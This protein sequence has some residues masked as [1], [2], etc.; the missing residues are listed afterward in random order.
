MGNLWRDVRYGLRKLANNKGFAAVA[1]LALALGIGPNVAIFSIIWATF[2]A[3]LPYPDADQLVVVWTKVRGERS[4]SRTDD[5]LQY[6]AQSRSFQNLD[7]GAWKVLH[8]TNPDHS[9]DETTGL[10]A[11]PGYFT[12]NQGV[13]IALGRDFLPEEGVPGKDHEVILTHRVW[14]ERFHGDPAI[15]G[16]PILID[17]QPY[18]VVG[19][20]EAGVRDRVDGVQFGVPLALTPGMH[21]PEWGN[22][23]GR[24]KRG[25]TIA[26]A[27]AEL[28]VIDRQLAATRSGD[29]PKNAWTISVEPLKNDWMDKKLARNLWLLLAA[30]GFVLLIACANLA[31]LLLAK[32]SSRQ[33][34]LAVRAAMGATRRQVFGQ[35]ITE[36]LTLAILGGAVGIALG[37][38]ILKLAMAIL[39]NL[40]TAEAVIQLNLPVLYFALG[41]TF[42]AGVL[43]GC[44]PAWQAA[45]FNLSE[46]LKQ[47]SRSVTG[48]G[49]MRTQGLLVMAEFALALTLLAGAGMA[50]HSFWNLTQIDFGVRTDNIVTGWLETRRHDFTNPDQISADARQLLDKVRSLPG[51]Q[52]ATIA[53]NM[54]LNGNGSFPFSIVGHPVA[55]VDRPVADYQIVTPSYF[56]TFGVRLARGRLL[57][58]NDRAGSPQVIIVSQSFVDRFLH[59]VNPLDQR[60][61]LGKLIPNQKIGPASEWQIVGVFHDIHNG[62]H[63][64]DKAA[65]Q[66]FASYW[67]IPWPWTWL[68][69]RTALDPGPISASIRDVVAHTLTGYSFAHVRTMQ[70]VVNTQM[71]GDRFGMVLFGGFAVLALL[72]SALGIYGVMAFAVVQRSH[73]IGLRMALG[74]QQGDVVRLILADGMKLSLTGVGIGL[75]GVFALGHLMRTTLYGIKTIDAGSFA[76]VAIV[77]LAVAV[78]ASYVPARR[79]AR[80][81][82][83]IALWQE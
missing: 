42:L 70:Q 45:R 74:A 37:W 58:D 6:L 1:I 59:G 75:V 77:L 53:T 11:T 32:G 22:I 67:Q 64:G 51:L 62:Q 57:N 24:L 76:A 4:P 69:V 20:L 43:F 2:L 26:Q 56:E 14:L 34:E 71:T 38:A 48:R 83:M 66:I 60:L 10:P 13:R 46:T 23:F 33:Q 52:N 25:V 30:V 12:K 9:Q 61:L 35:L 80:V 65:P 54:P 7:F 5:Y 50:L 41:A 68:A 55:V 29:L 79:S 39:P 18:T 63:L 19:V 16:K 44:L 49:R 27:Q 21:T 81:D 31:N 82:P 28:S 36:S 72:L 40:G 78:L 8:L 3:P 47:G 73:E 15:L 17:D